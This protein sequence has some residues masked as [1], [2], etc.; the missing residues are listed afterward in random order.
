[1]RKLVLTLILLIGASAAHAQSLGSILGELG[2]KITAKDSTNNSSGSLGGI[3]NSVGGVVENLTA[4]SNFSIE[5][6][7]GTWDYESPAVSMSSDNILSNVGGAAASGTIEDELAGY[8]KTFGLDKMHLVVNKD[9]TFTMNAGKISLSGTIDK[10]GEQLV[11]NFKALGKI[12][13]GKIKA[14]ATMSGTSLNLTFEAKKLLTLLTKVTSIT[15]NSTLSSLSK[16]LS[17]YK[18]LY[19]GTKLRKS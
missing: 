16:L 18:D 4:S 11:F 9:L 12:S 19:I 17:Q 10:S 7:I 2:S 13:L 14:R 6:M 3:L 1:M 8:Y 15:N 5:R